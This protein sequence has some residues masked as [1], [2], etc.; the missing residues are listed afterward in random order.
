[1]FLRFIFVAPLVVVTFLVVGCAQEQIPPRT[2]GDPPEAADILDTLL[3]N[4]IS[5]GPPK[6]GIPAVDQPQFVTAEQADTWLQPQDVVFGIA[7]GDT[8]IAFPQRIL[9]WHEIANIEVGGEPRSVTYC[10]LTGTAIGFMGKLSQ[11]QATTFGV[12]GKLV[13]SNLLL[14]DRATDSLWPQILGRAISGPERGRF[15]QEFPVVFT[16]WERWRMKYPSTLVLSR[17]TGFLRDYSPVGDPYGSYLE[18]DG[19]YYISDRVIFP[20]IHEDDRLS[21]KTV[22]VGVRDAQGNAAAVTKERLR[23]DGK[24]EVTLG[25]IPVTII[26]DGDLD[27]HSA[28]RKDTGA[29]VNSLQAFWFAWAAFYPETSLLP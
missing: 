20:L 3:R 7:E 11:G 17:E 13:N 28:R 2:G 22:V 21:P 1:M 29:W 12:S 4:V 27:T 8:V 5:G 14:Y 25:G 24:T 10:P 6:D 18:D 16:T 23:R 19:G 9:V 26:Y 15:L